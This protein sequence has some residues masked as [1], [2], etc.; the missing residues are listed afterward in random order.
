MKRKISPGLHCT[1]LD[2][3]LQKTIAADS[4]MLGTQQSGICVSYGDLGVFPECF[5]EEFSGG[6]FFCKYIGKD[7]KFPNLGDWQNGAPWG[8]L[9]SFNADTKPRAV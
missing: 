8:H 5:Q 2:H 7:F 9:F 3:S 1:F 6:C 4:D